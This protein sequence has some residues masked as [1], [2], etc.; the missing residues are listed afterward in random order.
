MMQTV[1]V[2]LECEDGDFVANVVIPFNGDSPYVLVWGE[3]AF[4]LHDE[5]T[6]REAS[7]YTIPVEAVK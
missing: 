6:Y 4:L 1:N 3:R 7:S 2:R 5:L